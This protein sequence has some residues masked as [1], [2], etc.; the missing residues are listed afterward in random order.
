M[1]RKIKRKTIYKKL[2]II[3]LTIQILIMNQNTLTNSQIL[4]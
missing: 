3:T 2:K 4:Q 1:P